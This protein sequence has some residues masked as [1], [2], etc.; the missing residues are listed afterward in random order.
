MTHSTFQNRGLWLYS[1]PD[2]RKPKANHKLKSEPSFSANHKSWFTRFHKPKKSK[3]KTSRVSDFE[4]AMAWHKPKPL[5]HL[6]SQANLVCWLTANTL[7]VSYWVRNYSPFFRANEKT[8]WKRRNQSS[9]S[10][11]NRSHDSYFSELWRVRDI[12][13]GVTLFFW[14]MRVQNFRYEVHTSGA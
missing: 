2:C 9:D 8:N 1:P 3:R 5:Q 6:V 10:F 4:N 11:E 14:E 7:V 13:V 12:F